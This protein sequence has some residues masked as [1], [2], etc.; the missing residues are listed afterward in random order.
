MA[1]GLDLNSDMYSDDEQREV[2]ARGEAARPN[3]E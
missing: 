2:Q 3:A 1:M